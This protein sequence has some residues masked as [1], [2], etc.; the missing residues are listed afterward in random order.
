MDLKVN[1]K[2]VGKR[3]LI[4]FMFM[5]FGFEFYGIVVDTLVEFSL[6][7]LDFAPHIGNAIAGCLIEGSGI[8]TL[9]FFVNF[10]YNFVSN[11]DMIT[12]GVKK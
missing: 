3:P 7:L 4:I 11:P 2:L 8:L 12:R 10:I 9:W 1:M 6:V 5:L